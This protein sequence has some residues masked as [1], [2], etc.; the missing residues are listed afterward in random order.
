MKKVLKLL[1]I[2][3]TIAFGWSDTKF[4]NIDL[5]LSFFEGNNSIVL[6]CHPMKPALPLHMLL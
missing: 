4:I 6:E 5:N 2:S 3:A 1:M